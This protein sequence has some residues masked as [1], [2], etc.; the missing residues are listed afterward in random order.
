M[1]VTEVAPDALDAAVDAFIA[2]R[3]DLTAEVPFRV[4]LFRCA[5]EEHVLV[6]LIHHI[7]SDG[8][9]GGPLARDLTTAYTARLEGRA[10]VYEP[11]AVTYKDY[12]LW[13]RELLG[14]GDRPG[15]AGRRAGELLAQGTERC[16]AAVEPAAGP[17]A[18]RGAE[19]P[20]ATRSASRCR[21]RWRPGCR[22]WPT[23][24]G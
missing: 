24:A 6:L 10:P 17:P 8:V 12:A 20:R 16:A 18:A 23:S 14:D 4:R 9:S 1:P 5:P 13:Q 15:L 2:H 11:L 19:P 21:R 3:F 7:A 22:S